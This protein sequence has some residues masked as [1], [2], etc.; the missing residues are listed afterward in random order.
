ML[1]NTSYNVHRH[2]MSIY[3]KVQHIKYLN[4]RIEYEPAYLPADA[5]GLAYEPAY[6]LADAHGLDLPADA[7]GLAL[8]ADARGLASP[9]A[10]HEIRRN[11]ESH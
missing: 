4:I 11:P 7:R 9:D 1:P 6:L 2:H 3:N 10:A 5:R 8:P